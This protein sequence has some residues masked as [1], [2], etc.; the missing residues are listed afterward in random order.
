MSDEYI[1][2]ESFNEAK[3]TSKL[4][5]MTKLMSQMGIDMDIMDGLMDPPPSGEGVGVMKGKTISNE[6]DKERAERSLMIRQFNMCVFLLLQMLEGK[7]VNQADRY[8]LVRKKLQ[9][10][11]EKNPEGPILKFIESTKDCRDIFNECTPENVKRLLKKVPKIPLLDFIDL[12]EN[13]GLMRE[14]DW[15]SLWMPLKRMAT[16]AN[17]RSTLNTAYMS[18]IEDIA[19]N[20]QREKNLSQLSQSDIFN[21][22]KPSELLMREDMR[23]LV[24][25]FAYSYLK[26]QFPFPDLAS[27][28]PR[29]S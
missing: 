2:D 6:T 26:D 11:I 15:K 19:M 12:K 21:Q 16:L 20:L 14:N 8:D 28:N 5:D 10:Q 4:G 13:A 23:E 27:L 18:K 9:R 29:R 3:A 1:S 7:F 24:N 17:V 25:D 22:I